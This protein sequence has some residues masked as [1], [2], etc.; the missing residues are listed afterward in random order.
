MVYVWGS[1][2]HDYRVG[3]QKGPFLP[4]EELFDMVPGMITSDPSTSC[5]FGP[6]AFSVFQSMARIE[7]SRL[8]RGCHSTGG[9]HNCSALF[10]PF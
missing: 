4:Q 7:Y 2:C 3:P 5:L 6:S 8:V 1:I 10:T 9:I